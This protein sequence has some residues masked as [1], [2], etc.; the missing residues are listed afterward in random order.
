MLHAYSVILYFGVKRFK[1]LGWFAEELNV[2][3]YAN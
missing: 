2:V 3:W 1:P